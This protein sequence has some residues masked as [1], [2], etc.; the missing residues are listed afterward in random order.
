VSE[1]SDILYSQF[2]RKKGKTVEPINLTHPCAAC[3]CVIILDDE[4]IIIQVPGGHVC[5][6]CK[7]F[8]TERAEEHKLKVTHEMI[9]RQ[10]GVHTLLYSDEEPIIGGWPTADRI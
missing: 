3:G 1:L 2:G 4:A 5:D 8:A 10:M 9:R 7:T 6:G